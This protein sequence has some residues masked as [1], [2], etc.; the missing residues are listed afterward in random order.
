MTSS[1]RR[2][3]QLL[4][5]LG[6]CSRKEAQGLCD[7]G[8]VKV[9][10]V[11][12]DDA[13]RR[14]DPD[15]V[16]LD[17][18]PLE[19]PHGLLVMIHKPVGLVCSHD[20]KE[21]PRVYDLLPER[22]QERDPKVTTIGR[23]DKETSGILLFTDQG[24]LVQ[25]LTSPKHHVD[26]VYEATLDREVTAVMIEAFERGLELNEGGERLQTLPAVLR[27]LGG[28]RAEVTLREGKYHQ[29]RRMFAAVGAHVETLARTRFGEWTLGD[30]PEGEWKELPLPAH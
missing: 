11:V 5:S 4:S 27:S 24:S 22:W 25:R 7:E 23:L 3:D 19:F 9:Q 13:S 21:G 17:G 10:G 26:K 12:L 16:R 6:Y 20:T 29:V 30:L 1:T 2:L 15:Q 28:K 8:L 18:E 14:V